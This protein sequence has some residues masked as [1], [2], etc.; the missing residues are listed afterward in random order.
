MNVETEFCAEDIKGDNIT[1]N[2]EDSPAF[3]VPNMKGY[4]AWGWG[5]GRGGV[6]A[7]HWY[8]LIL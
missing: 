5:R 2:V 6:R 3:S 1:A 8:M 7:E 4:S